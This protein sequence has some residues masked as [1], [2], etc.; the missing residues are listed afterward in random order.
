MQHIRIISHTNMDMDL[1][2]D[3]CTV[4]MLQ[5]KHQNIMCI[6]LMTHFYTLNISNTFGFQQ[7]PFMYDV[8]E[9]ML[10]IVLNFECSASV[11]CDRKLI[12]K[13]LKNTHFIF[14]NSQLFYIYS[15]IIVFFR[16]L[17]FTLIAIVLSHPFYCF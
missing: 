14:A 8:N 6:F 5:I 2:K 9:V 10:Y 1:N 16:C 11:G 15:H 12:P 4:I 3:K 7:K 13:V 17:W